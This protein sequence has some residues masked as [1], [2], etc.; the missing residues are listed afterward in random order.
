MKARWCKDESNKNVDPSVN[1]L[2]KNVW[3]KDKNLKIKSLPYSWSLV[4]GTTFTK[5]INKIL[6]GMGC[7]GRGERK[8]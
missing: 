1:N 4:E 6:L 2:W 3:L 5:V 8:R 7:G